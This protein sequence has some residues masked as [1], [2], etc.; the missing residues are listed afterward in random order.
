MRPLAFDPHRVLA[1]APGVGPGLR[2]A[3]RWGANHTGLPVILV[4]AIAVVVSFRIFR[5][6]LRFAIE[7]VLAVALLAAA[8]R[9]GWI[10]W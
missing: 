10:S 1:W 5:R 7:V 8:S 9:L 4:A 6:T 3:L 2:A